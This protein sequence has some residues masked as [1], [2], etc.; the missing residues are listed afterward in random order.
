[1]TGRGIDLADVVGGGNGFGSGK[2][3][4]GI[5]P[6]TG[7][8]E[9]RSLNA[10]DDRKPGRFAT[11]DAAMI[12]GVFI[13]AF[14]QTQISSTELVAAGLTDVHGHVIPELIKS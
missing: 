2:K 14:E 5:D 1:M 10:L 9:E 7:K 4:Q 8:S 12:D 11:C 3:G 13:P 6:R